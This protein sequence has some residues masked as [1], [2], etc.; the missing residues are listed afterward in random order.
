M[1][2]VAKPTAYRPAIQT[3]AQ[4]P[5]PASQRPQTPWQVQTSITPKPVYTPQYT[6]QAGNLAAALG[7]PARHD[8]A[9]QGMQRGISMQSPYQQW[10]MEARAANQMADSA[11][12]PLLLAMQ[13]GFAN[14]QNLLQGQQLRDQQAQGLAQLL[15]QDQ[16][17]RQQAQLGSQSNLIGFLGHLG[18][19]I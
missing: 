1:P 15:L 3:P 2:P 8:L 11:L 12:A 18:G 14:Q 10:G 16:A 5:Q 13:H 9:V 4:K 7:V 6:Q 19:Y 17:A